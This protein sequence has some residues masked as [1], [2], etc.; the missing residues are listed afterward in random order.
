MANPGDAAMSGKRKRLEH[1]AGPWHVEA[2]PWSRNVSGP[3]HVSIA[4]AFDYHGQ[5]AGEANARLIAA[6]PDLLKMANRISAIL[7]ALL[8]HEIIR[9][10]NWR[11]TVQREVL[12]VEKYL[13]PL[14]PKGKR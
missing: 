3:D 10:G 5:E 1:T 14:T 9:V 7:Q 11:D 2:N 4:L 12:F 6:A 8:D 13:S